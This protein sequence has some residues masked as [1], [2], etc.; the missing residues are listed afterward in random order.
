MLKLIGCLLFIPSDLLSQNRPATEVKFTA[1]AGT[2]APCGTALRRR[3]KLEYI[4]SS[5]LQL[6]SVPS[7]S[8][9]TESRF[10]DDDDV[11]AG[12]SRVSSR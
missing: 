4:L 6:S 10:N 3:S 12:W 2:R 8:H 9:I 7:T 5:L 11:R 1:K